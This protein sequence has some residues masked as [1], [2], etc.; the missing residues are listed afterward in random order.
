MNDSTW[1]RIS[2]S[3]TTNQLGV[4]ADT[5]NSIFMPG[6]RS[7]AVGWY[8]DVKRELWLFGGKGYGSSDA[9]GTLFCLD[10]K[11]KRIQC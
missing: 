3:N 9:L 8:N 6:A 2:G 5:S 1:T 7:A 4:Y 10:N 11:K